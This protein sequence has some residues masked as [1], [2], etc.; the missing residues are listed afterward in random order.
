MICVR[1]LITCAENSSSLGKSTAVSAETSRWRSV[2]QSEAAVNF[3]TYEDEEVKSP[4]SKKMLLI[5]LHMNRIF[6]FVRV[7]PYYKQGT[8]TCMIDMI[9]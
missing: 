2:L 9:S 5:V 7:H 6:N 8:I 1:K 4:K 3:Y